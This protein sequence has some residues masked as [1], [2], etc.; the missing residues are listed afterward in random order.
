MLSCSEVSC[1][2]GGTC[3]DS[4]LGFTCVCPP[5]FTGAYC[6]S[7]LVPDPCSNLTCR[8]NG[9]LCGRY[10]LGTHQKCDC[11]PGYE[12]KSCDEVIDYCARADKACIHGRCL[13]DT[14]PTC[15]CEAGSSGELCNIRSDYCIPDPCENGGTCVNHLESSTYSCI[16]PSG[17]EGVNCE[18]VDPCDTAPCYNDGTCQRLSNTEYR[19]VCPE[20]YT[21]ELCNE[22]INYCENSPCLNQ[23]TC[24]SLATTY[25]CICARGYKG[26]RCRKRTNPCSPNPCLN[27]GNCNKNETA[28]YGHIFCRCEDGFQG[29]FCE[30]RVPTCTPNPCLN[31]A[32]CTDFGNGNI[33]CTCTSGYM[34]QRCGEIRDPCIPSPCMNNGECIAHGLN[35]SCSCEDGY[36]GHNCEHFDYCAVHQC[37]NGG[38]CVSEGYCLCPLGFGGD[39]CSDIESKLPQFSGN[40]YMFLAPLRMDS[41]SSFEISIS[42]KPETPDGLI[43]HRWEEYGGDFISLGLQNGI[44]VYKFDCG[45]GPTEI[46]SRQKLELN[47][48]HVVTAVKHEENGTLHVSSD[49]DYVARGN[50]RGSFVHVQVENG[51]L[52][53]GGYSNLSAL[54]EKIGNYVTGF[55]GCISHL[56]MDGSVIDFDSTAWTLEGITQCRSSPCTTNSLDCEHGGVC[57]ASSTGYWCECP[58]GYTGVTCSRSTLLIVCGWVERAL[59]R[60]GFESWLYRSQIFF[61]YT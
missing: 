36:S 13:N 55:H 9:G 11:Y 44:I 39:N 40:S 20:G 43:F 7:E 15:V 25:K 60:P 59:R 5:G 34:G 54:P 61:L 53:L 49:P 33:L 45:T 41:T 23:A 26:L 42:I 29:E 2:N 37:A 4:T 16:C 28:P 27:N 52:Y 12:G 35:Y 30:E 47:Q 57:R 8:T 38:T 32:S 31:G 10:R 14:S 21:G 46:R 17:Y 56:E 19:C 18:I 22:T 51:L 24:V 50:S 58:T 48:W 6:D 3:Q 1:Q